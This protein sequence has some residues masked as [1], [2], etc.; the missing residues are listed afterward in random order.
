MK[1][2]IITKVVFAKSM[3]EAIMTE[4]NGEMVQV[5]LDQDVTAA[6][7]IAPK[8]GFKHGRK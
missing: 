7:T 3:P 1:R 8:I 6:E 4:A 5:S 2:Y